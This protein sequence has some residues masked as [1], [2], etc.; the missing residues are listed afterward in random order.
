ME[1]QI[2]LKTQFNFNRINFLFIY[3]L[4]WVLNICMC[5]FHQSFYDSIQLY[6]LYPKN[7]LPHKCRGKIST[8]CRILHVMNSI[9]IWLIIVMQIFKCNQSPRLISMYLTKSVFNEFFDSVINFN[10]D[11]VAHHFIF[12]YTCNTYAFC[13]C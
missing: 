7:V 8:D 11:T 1:C 10:T 3:E 6:T 4:I 5:R 12:I 13:C 2:L 9:I